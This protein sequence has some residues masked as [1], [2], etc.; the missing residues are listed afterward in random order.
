[1]LYEVITFLDA[2]LADDDLLERYVLHAEVAAGIDL[3]DF[4]YRIHAL[5]HVSEYGIAVPVRPG[6]VQ[7]GIVDRVDEELGGR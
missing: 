2:D 5:G 1:M 3:L 4:L 6:I 7:S